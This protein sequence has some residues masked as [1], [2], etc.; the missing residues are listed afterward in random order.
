MNKRILAA[1]LA[2]TMSACICGCSESEKTTA[3]RPDSPKATVAGE[4]GTK[5]DEDLTDE[6][7][8]AEE[9]AVDEP[10]L[11]AE[12]TV[13]DPNAEQEEGIHLL[14]TSQRFVAIDDKNGFYFEVELSPTE[15]ASG[16]N[17]A[18]YDDKGEKVADMVDVVKGTPDKTAGDNIFSCFFKPNS[19]KAA[20]YNL[21]AKIGAIETPS[22]RVRLYDD[23]DND[24]FDKLR[25]V[26]ADFK[27]IDAKYRDN[28][29]IIPDD[30]RDAA[31][32]EANALAEKMYDSGEVIEMNIDEKF[33]I[34]TI[35]LDSYLPYV[36]SI[37]SLE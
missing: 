24:D 37:D 8:T 33:G 21:T 17:V 16:I 11:T 2:L 10:T 22:V 13:T 23:F 20:T 27:A 36:Y 9:T 5:I 31:F 25:E 7:S 6:E 30:K 19:K 35:W 14:K 1:A 28:T 34:I 26:T 18:L 29:G 3:E 15:A 12:E 32:K 4:K